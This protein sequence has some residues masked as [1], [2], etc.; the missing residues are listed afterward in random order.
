M[1]RSGIMLCYPFEEK[2]LLKWRPPYI[3][4][5]KLD[6]DRMRALITDGYAA[7]FSSEENLMNNALPHIA[8]YL[9]NIP[10][11]NFMELDGEAYTHGMCHEEIH[12]IASR[13]VNFH[14]NLEALEYHI[15]DVVENC[16]MAERIDLLLRL[17]E[18]FKKVPGPC[19]V[20]PFEVAENLDDVM[21]VYDKFVGLGY[22]GIIIRDHE[23]PYVRKRSTQVMKFKPKKED[24]YVIIGYQEEI[25]IE[26]IPKGSLG[27]LVCRANEGE[28]TFNVGTG[29]TAD[30]RRTLWK[31]R[32]ELPGKV[33]KVAYQ[34]I[35]SGRGVPRFPVFC[36]IIWDLGQGEGA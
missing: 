11:L 36:E 5:P 27:A 28:G 30:D 4:Q 19:H 14:T 29:F 24:F 23:A 25:S 22:E 6:G 3:I 10:A 34:H 18:I 31:R 17:V 15:F 21:R 26:G 8:N 12:G 32:E 33:V 35:T 9:G 7:L 2:R 20:V 13:R 16:S 1:A